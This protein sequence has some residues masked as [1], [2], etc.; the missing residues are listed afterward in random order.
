MLRR[1]AY[2]ALATLATL[3]STAAKAITFA[4][5]QV[6]VIDAANSFP[7][8]DVIVADGPGATTTTVEMVP[9]GEIGTQVSSQLVAQDSSLVNI[10]GGII[11]TTLSAQDTSTVNMSGGEVTV[12]LE[13]W[14]PR[15]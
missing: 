5:G 8:E 2:L 12:G 6:H 3:T 13:S 15:T 9:G 10:S 7:L 14:E 1:A 4:D 11:S